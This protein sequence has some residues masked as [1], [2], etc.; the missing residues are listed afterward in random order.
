MSLLTLRPLHSTEVRSHKASGP[1]F[2]PINKIHESQGGVARAGEVEIFPI[3]LHQIRGEIII[4]NCDT[5]NLCFLWWGRL[6]TIHQGRFRPSAN[7]QKTCKRQG[8]A[9]PFEP[10]YLKGGCPLLITPYACLLVAVPREKRPTF[11]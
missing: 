4:L 2:D 11:W 5:S 1:A 3:I 7:L 10:P 8:S 6:P 9:A